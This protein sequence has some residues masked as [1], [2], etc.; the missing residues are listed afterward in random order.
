M[1]VAA[2]RAE[3]GAV[4]GG[5]AERRTAL[6][7]GEPARAESSTVSALSA[8]RGW[9]V[10]VREASTEALVAPPVTGAD[11]LAVVCRPQDEAL[12]LGSGQQPPPPE[13]AGNLHLAVVRRRSGGAA[14]MVGPGAQCWI[15]VFL[16]ASDPLVLPDVART[17]WWL[18]EAWA[19]AVGSV[20]AAGGRRAPAAPSRSAVEPGGIAVH[21][22]RSERNAFSS[23]ACWAGLGPGEVSLGG[24]KVVGLSQ[25]RTS[26]G[27]WLFTMALL[28]RDE[29]RLSRALCSGGERAELERHLGERTAALQVPLR[30]LEQAVLDELPPLPPLAHLAPRAR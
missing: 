15:D 25:R 17:A 1:T 8:P 10:M 30:R 18:G 24:A 4:A 11:R 27:V 19:R 16:P 20:V 23:L 7:A 13:L 28:H 9:T 26:A 12:V 6:D 2:R 29:G 5:A 3:P 14:V 22:E 21:R